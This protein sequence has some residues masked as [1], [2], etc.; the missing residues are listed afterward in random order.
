VLS[1]GNKP[2]EL[3]RKR[4]ADLI[5]QPGGNSGR[6]TAARLGHQPHIELH[7][8]SLG[9]A[10]IRGHDAVELKPDHANHIRICEAKCAVG[11]LDPV[12]PLVAMA[13]DGVGD[14]LA[15]YVEVRRGIQWR[16]E[17]PYQAQWQA[18]KRNIDEL[19]HDYINEGWE[20]RD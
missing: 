5:R 15:P 20:N 10:G 1:G 9:V 3:H 2:V 12:R 4:A 6:H 8:L 7:D 17:L 19:R 14:P 11:V 18:I 16:A 13:A